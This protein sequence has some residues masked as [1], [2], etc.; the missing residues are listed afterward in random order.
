MQNVFNWLRDVKISNYGR[1][2]VSKFKEN[3]STII[4]NNFSIN[5]IMK[6]I[7]LH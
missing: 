2:K 4:K 7:T 1:I 6:C 3:N 5:M